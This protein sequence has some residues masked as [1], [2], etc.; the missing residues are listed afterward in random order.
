MS[1]FGLGL[2][3]LLAGAAGGANIPASCP[4]RQGAAQAAGFQTYPECVEVR[5]SGAI[6][7]GRPPI[8]YSWTIDGQAVASGPEPELVVWTQDHG[9][10]FHT[11]RFTAANTA[12]SSSFDTFFI[13]ES[14]ETPP[15]PD[16]VEN[17]TPSLTLTAFVPEAVRGAVQWRWKWGDGEISPWSC[18]WSDPTLRTLHTYSEPGTYEVK[19][20]TRACWTPIATSLPLVATVGDSDAIQVLQFEAQGCTAGFCVFDTGEPI[21]FVQAFSATPTSLA[22]DWDGDGSVDQV[23]S[24]PVATHVYLLPGIVRPS[25]TAYRGAHSHTRQHAEFILINAAG[26]PTIFADGFES[27]D[28]GCW[29]TTVG[30]PRVAPGPGCFGSLPASSPETLPT[31][32]NS[33]P[34]R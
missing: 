15:R 10:G 26:P 14:L 19:L 29:S 27:G 21:P 32:S 4:G 3:L 16:A 18:D 33:A 7:A 25:V 17:P 23:A 12:G 6:A 11:L 5:W 13:V 28:T 30:A 31:E 1:G 8:T 24:S 22:Y 20:Q 2:A 9:P 34:H